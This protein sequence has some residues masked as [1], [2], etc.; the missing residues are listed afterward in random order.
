MCFLQAEK[1]KIMDGIQRNLNS[2][3]E[4]CITVNTENAGYGALTCRIRSTSGR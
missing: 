1:C 4:Y 2:G 3:E